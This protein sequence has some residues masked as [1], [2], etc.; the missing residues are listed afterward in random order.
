MDPLLL[1]L[2]LIAALALPLIL[3]SRR[4]KRAM[5]EAQLLQDS[6]TVGDRVITTSGLYATVV[7][8]ADERTVDLE[9]GLGVR[10]TWLRLAIREKVTDEVSADDDGSGDAD[11][12]SERHVPPLD[13]GARTDRL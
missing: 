12:V 7:G 9:V 3:G 1:P 2:L 4:Q 5:A 6:L 11:G 8:T 10:T 13:N